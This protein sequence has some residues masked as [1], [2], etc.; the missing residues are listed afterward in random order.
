[1]TRGSKIN[2]RERDFTQTQLSRTQCFQLSH[3][4]QTSP[5]NITLQ[6]TLWRYS[7]LPPCEP[8]SL[9]WL[10]INGLVLSGD[11]VTQ[12]KC[13][14]NLTVKLQNPQNRNFTCQYLEYG[15]VLVSAEYDLNSGS[16]KSKSL[17]VYII[18]AA[19]AV[20]LLLAVAAGLF[21]KI[22]HKKKLHKLWT[23]QVKDEDSVIYSKVK[24]RSSEHSAIYGKVNRTA[25]Y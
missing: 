11:G 24:L 1:M 21:F 4:S 9:R 12:Q 2:L 3:F 8:D 15:S 5:E 6:C 13:Q 7:S 23:H 17:I 19:V 10:D 14:S 25:Q 22:K 16:S 18:S 20:L